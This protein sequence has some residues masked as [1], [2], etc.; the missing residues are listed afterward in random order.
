MSCGDRICLGH[1][2]LSN[3]SNLSGVRVMS[4]TYPDK[5]KLFSSSRREKYDMPGLRKGRNGDCWLA[6]IQISG[7][8]Y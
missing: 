4:S 3:N 7:V 2:K 6:L 1:Y 5:F 8:W